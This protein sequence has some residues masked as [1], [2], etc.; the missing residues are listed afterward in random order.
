MSPKALRHKVFKMLKAER[1]INDAEGI[2]KFGE[3]ASIQL[4]SRNPFGPPFKEGPGTEQQG[5]FA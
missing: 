3:S 5:R 1:K 4:F 2:K